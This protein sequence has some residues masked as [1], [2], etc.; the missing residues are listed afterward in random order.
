MRFM[1]LLLPV[2]EHHN[3]NVRQFDLI[4]LYNFPKRNMVNRAERMIKETPGEKMKTTNPPTDREKK[5]LS[6]RLSD[7]SLYQET[8]GRIWRFGK[9]ATPLM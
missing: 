3:N 5:I 8:S 1:T 2:V 6:R 7:H 9:Y 4:L